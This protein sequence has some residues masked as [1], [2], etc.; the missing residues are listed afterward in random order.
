MRPKLKHCHRL[1]MPFALSVIL[2]ATAHAGTSQATPANATQAI[3][4]GEWLMV[5]HNGL[6]WLV[7]GPT[8]GSV[9]VVVAVFSYGSD[10][11]IPPP[12]PP[13][14]KVTGVWIIEEQTDRTAVQGRVMDDPTWQAAAKAKGLTWKIEDDDLPAD[15]HPWLSVCLNAIQESKLVL[16]VVC[17]VDSDGKPVSVVPLPAT[18]EEMRALIGGVE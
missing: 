8:D 2:T 5:A 13:P 9:P 6:A 3:G 18:V 17:L 7:Y 1:L 4:L 15:K 14:G 12:P 16:P 11:P 10:V